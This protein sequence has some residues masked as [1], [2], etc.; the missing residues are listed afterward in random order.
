MR[1]PSRIWRNWRNPSPR[2]PSRFSSGTAHVAEGELARVGRAPADL[3][4]SA[5]R[6]RSRACRW[7]RSRLEIS[8]SPVRR[9]DRHAGGDVRAGVGDEDL[10]AVMIHCPSRSSA[11]VCVA[12]ASE[13]APGSVSPNAASLRPAARSGSH[14]LLLLLGAE[15]ED[16]HRPERR[17]RRDGD[18]DGGVDPR[19]LL[20]RDRVGERV[21]AGAAVLLRDRDAHEPELGHALDDLVRE[22]VLGVEL[23]GDRGDLRLGE[24]AHGAPEQLVLVGQV[25]AQAVAHGVEREAASSATRRT[26]KPVA[27]AFG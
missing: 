18:R 17:V 24:L 16:R 14:S 12:P 4:A 6:S 5:P 8:S 11:R 2:G 7:G 23:L 22:A 1:P 3:V 15:H 27:P 13:P 19:Q 25:V 26:P 10:R 21:A 9:R 20:D